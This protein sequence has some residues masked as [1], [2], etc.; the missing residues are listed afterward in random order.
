MYLCKTYGNILHWGTHIH[1]ELRVV[2]QQ[3]PTFCLFVVSKVVVVVVKFRYWGGL[4]DLE[5][6]HAEKGIIMCFI[7]TNK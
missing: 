4:T 5:Y 7:S 1:Y 6:G 2:P 3:T